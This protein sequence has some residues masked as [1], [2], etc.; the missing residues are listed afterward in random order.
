MSRSASPDFSGLSPKQRAMFQPMPRRPQLAVNSRESDTVRIRRVRRPRVSAWKVVVRAG[1]WLRAG[2]LLAFRKAGDRLRGR[3]SPRRSGV[4]LRQFFEEVGGTGIKVGQQLASRVDMLPFEVCAELSTL[5]D[6]VPTFAFNDAMNIIARGLGRAP[7]KVF[8]MI[9]PEPIG[10]ASIACVYQGVLHSGER[11][12]IK[13]Q[14]P[15][16]AEQFVAD[17]ACVDLLTRTMELLTLVRPGYFKHLRLELEHLFYQELDFV[18]EA[19]YQTLFRRQAKRAKLDWVSAPRVF[20][21][22]SD[23][24]VLVSEYVDGVLCSELVA[25]TETGDIASLTAFKLQGI[26]PR[27]VAARI[28]HQAWWRRYES[29]FFHADPHPANI[30][31]K[32]D[33][34]IVMIDFGSCGTTSARQRTND[35]KYHYYAMRDDSSAL[36]EIALNNAMPVPHIDVEE[37]RGH[38]ERYLWQNRLAQISKEAQW[39]ERTTAG[40]FLGVAKANRELGIPLMPN[41]LE[42]MRAS[43]LYDTLALRLYPKFNLNRLFARYGRKAERRRQR[44]HRRAQRNQSHANRL[45]RF[46]SEQSRVQESLRWGGYWLES[47][48]RNLPVEFHLVSRKSAYVVTVLLRL[49]VA[50]GVVAALGVGLG[51]LFEPSTGVE[52]DFGDTVQ[53]VLGHPTT[54]TVAGL[55]VVQ[56][57]RRISFRVRDP[58]PNG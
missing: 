54:L 17:V 30:I 36:V 24:E 35:L 23:L 13:V 29:T 19:R 37:F 26:E 56:A 39:W 49:M 14:R 7:A 41:M 11:V 1:Q 21:Q 40:V 57:L 50:L 31:V 44:E 20:H 4:R 2:C 45:A 15:G 18:Q 9:D 34:K 55:L 38:L 46:Y 16:A 52:R 8:A 48:T 12:A 51:T 3:V 10:S 25:A 5:T 58:D 28:L 27:R 33:S 53:G 22:F 6:R 42:I 32:P 47:L 43:L